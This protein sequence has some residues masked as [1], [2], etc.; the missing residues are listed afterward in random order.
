MRRSGLKRVPRVRKCLS[1]KVPKWES[2]RVE[3]GRSE[4][5]LRSRGVPKWE[6]A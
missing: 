5:W 4:E 2:A 1:G 6:S 3:M